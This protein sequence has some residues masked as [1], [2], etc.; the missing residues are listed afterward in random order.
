LQ[1]T[2]SGKVSA[3]APRN[4][5]RGDA[6]QDQAKTYLVGA[7]LM[8]LRFYSRLPTGENGHER[9]DFAAMV[10][11]LAIP[12]LIIGAGPA[13]ALVLLVVLGAPPFFAAATA[14][15]LSAIVTGAMAEDA[16]ADAMDGLFGGQT[17]ER[18]LEI[19]HDSR[20]GTYG[21]LGIVIPFA[22]RAFSLGALVA[23]APVAAAA[24]WLGATVLSRSGATWIAHQ[25]PPA[26]ADG[27]SANAGKLSTNSCYIGIGFAVIASFMLMVP[28]GGLGR[29]L[30]AIAVATIALV[31]WRQLLVKLIGG[32]TGDTIG[33]AQLLLEIAILSSFMFGMGQ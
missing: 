21:T 2:K 1:L 26:R 7:I 24:I 11:P 5:N 13:F 16:F 25:L 15:G 10:R 29:W 17:I 3:P 30:V 33:A 23:A 32:Q 12:S 14:L 9:F 18:R 19:M 22:L 20:H 28:L 27:I 4:D 8:G 31:L 6:P